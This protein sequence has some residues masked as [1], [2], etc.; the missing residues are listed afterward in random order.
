[1]VDLLK[2]V[3]SGQFKQKEPPPEAIGKLL[4]FYADMF[5]AFES[6][7]VVLQKLACSGKD[8]KGQQVEQSA[9]G[10]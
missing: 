1:M 7:P 3:S 10:R 2:L 4:G 9:W 6:S 8:D 5:T